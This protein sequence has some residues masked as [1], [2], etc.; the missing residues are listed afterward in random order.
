MNLTLS[1]AG[2]RVKPV[3]AGDLMST[4]GRARAGAHSDYRS[5]SCRNTLAP[6]AWA[7]I[8]Q[9]LVLLVLVIVG[10]IQA[11]ASATG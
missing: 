2:P 11:L 4:A 9:R 7:A 3:R 10:V 6:R 1:Y 8:R 5:C